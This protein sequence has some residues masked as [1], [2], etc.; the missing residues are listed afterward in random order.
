MNEACTNPDRQMTTS[1]TPSKDSEEGEANRTDS[2]ERRFPA[3]E[4]ILSRENLFLRAMRA[5]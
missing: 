3:V 5:S 4:V 1:S 2:T